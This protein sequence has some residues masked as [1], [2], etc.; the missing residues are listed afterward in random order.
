MRGAKQRGRETN[1]DLFSPLKAF[2]R[3]DWLVCSLWESKTLWKG[4]LLSHEKFIFCLLWRALPLLTLC[5]CIFNLILPKA[6]PSAGLLNG[7]NLQ[8]NSKFCFI[9][10][11]SNCMFHRKSS[12]SVREGT[13]PIS[14]FVIPISWHWNYRDY[15]RSVTELAQMCL[16]P[17]TGVLLVSV[18]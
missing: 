8:Q 1:G 5:Y 16:T 6:K 9:P 14:V 18:C 15:S 10:Q 4:N 17:W 11:A 12:T 7:F 2:L 3:S 13:P